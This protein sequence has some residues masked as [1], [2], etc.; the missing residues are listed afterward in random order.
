MVDSWFSG[1][2]MPD[3][4]P[5]TFWGFLESL[6]RVALAALS[7]EP[8][9][10][11]FSN[12]PGGMAVAFT[13]LG[14]ACLSEMGGQSVI[15]FANRISHIRFNLALLSG[16]LGLAINLA[17]LTASI[18][19]VGSFLGGQRPFLQVLADVGVSYAPFL[20]GLLVF[21]PYLGRIIEQILRLWTLLT[22]LT[23]VQVTFGFSIGRALVCV[24]L[25]WTLMRVLSY[26]AGRPT[27]RLQ[28]WLL[29]LAGG[30][31]VALQREQLLADVQQEAEDFRRVLLREPEARPRTERR[32]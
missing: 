30:R 23:A 10:F 2:A 8:W 15:L 6:W 27:E 7:L 26:L 19:L 3:L 21:I 4:D 17:I 1:A 13:L 28:D 20:L 5:K 29:E 24:L 31:E 32:L 12:S 25:G 9:A 18:W 22:L 11:Q 16:A 14:L